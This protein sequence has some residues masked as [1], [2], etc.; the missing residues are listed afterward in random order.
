M[1]SL[2]DQTIG[3]AENAIDKAKAEF[4]N[5]LKNKKYWGMLFLCLVILFLV[6]VSVIS[7]R[8]SLRISLIFFEMVTGFILYFLL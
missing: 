5:M 2:A 7:L 1:S 3:K 4:Q 8:A 6:W